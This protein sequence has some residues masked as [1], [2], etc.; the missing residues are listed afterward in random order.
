VRA[1][2]SVVLRGASLSMGSATSVK[3]ESLEETV[4]R[5][6]AA[7]YASKAASGG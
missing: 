5:A 1:G 7:M 6:D 2:I 4:H 3:G